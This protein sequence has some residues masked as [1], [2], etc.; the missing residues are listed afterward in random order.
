MASAF[1]VPLY[2]PVKFSHGPNFLSLD[3]FPDFCF[4]QIFS[5]WRGLRRS[6]LTTRLLHRTTK[7][8]KQ[9]LR[10][11]PSS[12]HLNYFQRNLSRVYNASSRHLIYLNSPLVINLVRLASCLAV[13]RVS[14]HPAHFLYRFSLSVF[15]L[16]VVRISCVLFQ[17][18][19][20]RTT[21][22]PLK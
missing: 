9:H 6:F 8:G 18:N 22:L 17:L 12:I 1:Q 19:R 20:F 10:M 21:A 13:C 16:T 4:A 3:T 5:A 11:T 2:C 14:H 15:S 7:C